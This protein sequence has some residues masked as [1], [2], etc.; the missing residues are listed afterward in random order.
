[1]ARLP[2]SPDLD[3]R[4]DGAPVARAHDD[5]YFSAQ[6][7]LAETQAVFLAGC[8]LPEAWSGR[9]AF[10]VAETGFGTGLNFLALW[11]MWQA[12]APSETA[13]LHFVSFEGFPLQAEDAARALAA[14]PGLSELSGQLL[15]RWPH[16]AMGTRRIVWSEARISLTLHIGDIH[17]TLPAAQFQADAWFLD[18]FSPAKN[19]VMWGDWIYPEIAARSAP[20]ARVGTFTVAGHVRRG[21]AAAGFVV[22]KAPGHGRK[23]NRL[24]AVFEG[25]GVPAA[26]LYGLRG[27]GGAVRRIAVIGG[28][29]AGVTAAHA[30]EAAG[31]SVTLFEQDGTLMSGASGNA[32]ALVMPRLDAGDTIEARVLIDAYIAARDLYRGQPGVSETDVRHMPRDDK[33]LARFAKLL[34]DPPL[35]LEDLEALRGGGVLHK[36]ALILHPHVLAEALVRRVVVQCG[37]SVAVDVSKRSVNGE[38]FDVI[39]LAN[40]M[41]AGDLVGGLSMQARLGQVEHVADATRAEPSAIT[42]GHYALADGTERLWGA[43]FEAAQGAPEVSEASREINRQALEGLQPW[44]L[45]Q[46]RGQPGRSRAGIRATT[47]DFLPLIGAALDVTKAE[48]AFAGLRDGR[49]PDVDAP[50]IEGLYVATGYGSRGFTW[51]PWAGGL[52]A[53]QIMS[54]PAAASVS[55]L[56]AVSPSRLTYRA[57]K[58]G[59]PI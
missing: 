56:Q 54:G 36:R 52:L 45:A 26:D 12:H 2:K 5:V 29:I 22:S 19:E 24:E 53:A 30:L 51:G 40:G 25:E 23:R 15:A 6:D 31:A 17:D 32:M 3:W 9:E 13:W 49:M 27:T 35:P 38:A 48:A 41:A 33:E 18:G 16:G 21:L 39:V 14:W 57:M 43:T 1:M 4:A 42:S 20:G 8:R 28:G 11:Q 34:A 7:G 58:R 44:W 50:L 47:P 55:V 10:T 37:A 46:V 59:Q